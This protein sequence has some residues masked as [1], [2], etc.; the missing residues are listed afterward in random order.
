MISGILKYV[1]IVFAVCAQLGTTDAAADIKMRALTAWQ[2]AHPL[3]KVMDRY[4]ENVELATDGKITFIKNGPEVV[5]PFEQ[6]E[7][8]QKNIFQFLLTTG[9]YNFGVDGILLGADTFKPDSALIRSAGV[10]DW[11]DRYYQEK[12]NLKLVAIASAGQF[13]LVLRSPPSDSDDVLGRNIRG[14]INYHSLIRK[15]HG[16]PVAMPVSQIYA[17]LEKGVVDGFAFAQVGLL[18]LKFYEVGA[19]Y[20]VRPLFG[21]VPVIILMNLDA[22]QQLSDRDQSIILQE[23]DRVEQWAQKY[24]K[25]L[26]IEEENSL[27]DKGVEITNWGGNSVHIKKW[28]SDGVWELV[29]RFSHEDGKKFH[30]FA[31]KAGVVNDK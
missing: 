24:Y 14:T 13:Q 6:L 12:F 29:E 8:T 18:Q 27:R 1:I 26:A 2:P 10:F 11:M 21:Q 28:F 31:R 15:L 22:F 17:A 19:K 23:G 25:S 20:L 4:I 7:P 3:I 30:E 16:S 5:P 9:S